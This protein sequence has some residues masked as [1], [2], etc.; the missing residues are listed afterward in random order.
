MES[1]KLKAARCMLPKLSLLGKSAAANVYPGKKSKKGNPT[2]IRKMLEGKKVM[3]TIS[4]IVR[5]SRNRSSFRS[6]ILIA[7]NPLAQLK[8]N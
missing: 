4:R 7:V 2:I 8:R 6:L 3:I 1:P 5:T